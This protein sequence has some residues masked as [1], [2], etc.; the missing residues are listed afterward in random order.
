MLCFSRNFWYL[1]LVFKTFSAIV[2]QSRLFLPSS[3]GLFGEPDFDFAYFKY[4]SLSPDNFFGLEQRN[5]QLNSRSWLFY[6]AV[7][8][9]LNRN[10]NLE[11][12][13]PTLMENTENHWKFRSIEIHH[14]KHQRNATYLSPNFIWQPSTPAPSMVRHPPTIPTPILVSQLSTQV[15]II[16]CVRTNFKM[17]FSLQYAVNFFQLPY[18]KFSFTAPRY[19]N[20]RFKR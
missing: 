9:D 10:I 8:I 13:S 3:V 19:H 20:S 11:I 15:S 16:I 12:V 5:W 7:S 14:H 6:G 18:F 4:I 17:H 1:T 2:A